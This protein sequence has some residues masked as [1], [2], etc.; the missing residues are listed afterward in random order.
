MQSSNT[1]HDL[2][3]EDNGYR[4]H[5]PVKHVRSHDIHDQHRQDH[6]SFRKN[7]SLSSGFRHSIRSLTACALRR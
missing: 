4:Q 6:S 2:S 3:Q 5:K 1:T 7:R